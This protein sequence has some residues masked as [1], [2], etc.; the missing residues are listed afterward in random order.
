MIKVTGI[1]ADTFTEE[2]LRSPRPVVVEFFS[3]TCRFCKRFES[4]FEALAER[5]EGSVKFCQINAVENRD[6]ALEYNVV[7]VPTTII[8]EGGEAVER[9]NGLAPEEEVARKIEGVL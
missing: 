3:P 2:V 8:F 9:F 4:V 6:L 5:Y 7:G 1:D